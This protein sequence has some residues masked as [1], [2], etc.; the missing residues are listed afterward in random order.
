MP[1][2]EIALWTTS[3]ILAV[4]GISFGIVA[5]V[6]SRKANMKVQALVSDSWIVEESQKRFFKE[7]QRIVASNNVAIREL[8]KGLKFFDYSI[9]SSATRWAPI[10]ERVMNTLKK[11]EYKDIAEHF[12]DMKR[13]SDLTFKEIVPDFKILSTDSKISEKTSKELVKF[14][15]Q[16]IKISKAIMKE[17]IDLM[18]PTNQTGV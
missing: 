11:S 16:I 13:K 6:N 7:M 10:P 1:G 2:Y 18:S 3:L 9:L 17:Y 12:M 5:S 4:A 8:R 15:Q 14:H